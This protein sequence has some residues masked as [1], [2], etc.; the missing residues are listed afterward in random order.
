M[1]HPDIQYDV[2]RSFQA[3][4]MAQQEQLRSL[5][6]ATQAKRPLRDWVLWHSGNMLIS[7][8]TSLKCQVRRR[9]A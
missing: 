1:L 5:R 3:E 6:P 4:K 7:F 2:H 9:Y 8:G